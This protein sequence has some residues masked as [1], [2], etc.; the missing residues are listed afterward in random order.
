MFVKTESVVENFKQLQK[1]DPRYTLEFGLKGLLNVFTLH[2]F[3]GFELNEE[4]F[5]TD[6]AVDMYAELWRRRSIIEFAQLKQEVGLKPEEDPDM[7]TFMEM[8][9]IYFNT[10]GNPFEIVKNGP[11]IYEGKVYDCPYT[12]EIVFPTFDRKR[13]DHFNEAVQVSCN[14]AIFEEFLR[15]AKLDDK[16]LFAFPNQLCRYGGSC[17]FIFRKRIKY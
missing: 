11:D 12:T 16:W 5:G 4:K 17:G 3:L 14:T 9:Q 15:Q 8:V 1:K 2:D 6:T 10:F 7:P 13:A